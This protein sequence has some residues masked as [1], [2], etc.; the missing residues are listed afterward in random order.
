MSEGWLGIGSWLLTSQYLYN[1]IKGQVNGRRRKWQVWVG[2]RGTLM[3]Q[4]LEPG[5]GVI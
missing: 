5:E 1:D 4:Q 2:I 3:N